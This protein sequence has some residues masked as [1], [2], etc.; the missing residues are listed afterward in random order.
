[1]AAL[2][3]W[4][5]LLGFYGLSGGAHFEP[6]DCWVAQTAREMLNANEWA[7][8]QFAG[9]ARLHKS[10]GPY[11]AVMLAAML[12]GG[13]VD[14]AATRIPNA[15]AGVVLI[16]TI[17]WLAFHIAGQRAAIY[18][19]FAGASSVFFLYW[20]HRGASD[21]GLTACT[22]LSL[23]ALWIACETEGNGRRKTLL[24]WVGYFAA[25]LGML[26]KLP[27]PLVVVGLPALAYVVLMRRWS[28]FGS[29]KA[30][31]VGLAL[32]LTPW[33]PWVI[34]VLSTEPR[35]WDKWR[36]EYLDRFTGDLPNVAGQDHWVWW[37]LY[38]LPPLI[39][40]LPYSLSLPGAVAVP[41]RRL[42]NVH[43]RGGWFL[44]IWFLSLLVFLTV[45]TGKELRYFL[46]ALPPL[47]VLL[48]IDLSELFGRRGAIG[49]V[50]AVVMGLLRWIAPLLG[51]AVVFAGYQIWFHKPGLGLVE[52]APHSLSGSLR[53]WELVAPLSVAVGLFCVGLVIAANQYR[54]GKGDVAFAAFVG[55]TW[56]AWLWGWPMLFPILV[57]QAG[58]RDFANQVQQHVPRGQV[59]QM[60]QIAN[61]DPRVVWYGD[62]RF[63]R[64]INQLDMLADQHGRRETAYEYQ[65]YG[66]EI[67]RQLSGPQPCLLVMGFVEY[68]MFMTVVNEAAQQLGRAAPEVHVWLRS[69]YGNPFKSVLL[70]SNRPPPHRESVPVEIPPGMRARLLQL[71]HRLFGADFLETFAALAPAATGEAPRQPPVRGDI[72]IDDAAAVP[73]PVDSPASAP[74]E[75]DASAASAPAAPP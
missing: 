45:S 6:T 69:Q 15:A 64:L 74:A 12:R 61:H 44:V 30:H 57:S 17:C 8:P 13:Q 32:F 38:L 20:S 43:P 28:V 59:E 41:L 19:G 9:E 33:L 70:V 62:L 27:M 3:A 21:L 7:I 48:G 16:A 11:W 73:G 22:T 1:M 63:P 71:A 67:F 55:G 75:N 34:R 10:P 5:L 54:K 53:P 66:E 36:V 37:F 68:A 39:Y 60:R 14:E 46:P 47:L 56:A 24:L 4:S 18:A 31:A 23:A 40:C 58:F 72:G 52:P 49:R 42:P 26:Y 2:L 25:G 51:V 50:A 29:W 65:R 35:A